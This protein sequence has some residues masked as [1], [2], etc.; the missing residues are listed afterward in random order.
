MDDSLIPRLFGYYNGRYLPTGD[1]RL[2]V[3]DLLILRGLGVFD[4][5]RTYHRV[6]F[7][8]DD[9]LDRFFR[10]AEEMEIEPDCSK[11]HLKEAIYHLAAISPLPESAF[12]LILTP[13]M[14]DHS[15]VPGQSS[16][17]VLTEAIHPYPQSWYETGI[18]VKTLHFDRYRPLAK[19]VMY[20]QAVL[21][22]AH[23]KKQGFQEV[24]YRSGEF[25]TEGTTCNL[26]FCRDGIVVTPDQFILHG[27]RRRFVMDL[28]VKAGFTVEE[29]PVSVSEIGSFTDCFITSTTREI[30]PVCRI[31][32]LVIGTGTPGSVTCRLRQAYQ[33]AVQLTNGTRP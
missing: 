14:G 10:S 5:L 33:S 1:I 3:Y 6:P 12:R 22:L 25:L 4:F 28:A 29:R 31:D 8:L 13:G 27:T 15:L 21:E 9:H 32:S 30:L 17:V 19:S 2:P 20:S 23:A 11:A 24:I 26:F 7:L 16:V 18:S